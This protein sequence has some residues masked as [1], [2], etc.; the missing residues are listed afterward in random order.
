MNA[1][2]L[3]RPSRAA[4]RVL[5]EDSA[6]TRAATAFL[7]RLPVSRSK[8][9]GS[10]VVVTLWLAASAQLCPSCCETRARDVDTTRMNR[11]MEQHGQREPTS[12]R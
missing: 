5:D 12:L 7:A 11:M 8:A 9:N 2:A 10:F 6:Q 4:R 1:R 3:F